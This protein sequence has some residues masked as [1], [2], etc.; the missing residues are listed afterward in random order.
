MD[1]AARCHRVG[2]MHEGRLLVEGE[3]SVLLAAFPHRVYRVEGG[4]R[5]TVLQ[6]LGGDTR[7]LAVSPAGAR[8]RLV[9]ERDAEAGIATL[10]APL[11]VHLVPTASDFE[12]L[13]V[14]R[15]GQET[16]GGNA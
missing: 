12:D 5:D 11:G 8:L 16:R 6:A 9:L 2:L 7:V 1:E 15:L 14:A 10:L 4:E 3:P 13:F